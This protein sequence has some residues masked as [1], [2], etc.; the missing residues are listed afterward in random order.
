MSGSLGIVRPAG[1]GDGMSD[2]A[3]L[4][5]LAV[6]GWPITLTLRADGARCIADLADLSGRVNAQVSEIDKTEKRIG[7][8][9]RAVRWQLIVTHAVYVSLLLAVWWIS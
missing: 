7:A 6:A 1:R 2:A 3:Y 9:L 5:C 8:A 4:R